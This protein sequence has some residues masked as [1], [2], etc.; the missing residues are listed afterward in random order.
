[1]TKCFYS[2]QSNSVDESQTP[3]QWFMRIGSV[4]THG[5]C[6]SLTKWIILIVSFSGTGSVVHAPAIIVHYK[7]F[8]IISNSY[9]HKTFNMGSTYSE[10]Q[11]W[12]DCIAYNSHQST[13][14]PQDSLLWLGSSVL[15]RPLGPEISL[16]HLVQIK[17]Y[18]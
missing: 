11:V 16:I 18:S 14:L 7:Q 6:S 4:L 1:M 15:M 17:Y 13:H 9:L 3:L 8:Q 2:L 12:L 10:A 5:P